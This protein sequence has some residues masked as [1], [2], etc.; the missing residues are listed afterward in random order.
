MFLYKVMKLYNI[1]LACE[2]GAGSSMQ[3]PMHAASRDRNGMNGG[4]VLLFHAFRAN[5]LT[6]HDVNSLPGYQGIEVFE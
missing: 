6:L 1:R 3:A 2:N 5:V 4:K